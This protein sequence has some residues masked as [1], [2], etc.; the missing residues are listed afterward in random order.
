MISFKQFLLERVPDPPAVI[1]PF[2]TEPT[3]I[4]PNEW[5][6][7]P[8]FISPTGLK[9]GEP[10]QFPDPL[11]DADGDGIEDREDGDDDNDGF[12][13]DDDHDD[14]GD[15]VPDWVDPDWLEQNK[16][17]YEPEDLEDTDGDGYPDMWDWDANGNGIMDWEENGGIWIWGPPEDP[18]IG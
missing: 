10:S 4:N 9:P 15:N 16:G 1:P 18:E 17:N 8:S 14:D 5:S 6:R 11:W 2:I 13:D 3:G 7:P 12:R